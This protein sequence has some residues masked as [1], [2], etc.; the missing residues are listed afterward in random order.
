M[1]RLN[2]FLFLPPADVVSENSL[3]HDKNNP[4]EDTN[5]RKKRQLDTTGYPS[6]NKLFNDMK[7]LKIQE[8]NKLSDPE[9]MEAVVREESPR[10]N[11]IETND[12]F[13]NFSH[14]QKVVDDIINTLLEF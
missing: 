10:K 6:T 4:T 2:H 7:R 11:Q 9:V 1:F 5:S 8:F 12:V 13:L 14:E 3:N